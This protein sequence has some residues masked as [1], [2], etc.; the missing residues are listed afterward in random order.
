MADRVLIRL[1]MTHDYDMAVC[2]AFRLAA[3]AGLL[4]RRIGADAL[5][6]LPDR[7]DLPASVS[8][9]VIWKN[10]DIISVTKG[11]D[12]NFIP[13]MKV[14]IGAFRVRFGDDPVDETVPRLPSDRRIVQ[15]DVELGQDFPRE[16]DLNFAALS[17]HWAYHL[18]GPGMRDDL[19]IV[20]A[21]GVVQFDDLGRQVLAGGTPARVLRSALPLPLRAR[22]AQRFA[23]QH[24]DRS[25][26]RVLIPALPAAGLQIR[27]LA[28]T[29]GAT[30][31]QS[32]IYVTLS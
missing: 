10:S 24:D 31:F 21:E 25:G 29:D 27:P 13:V 5:V 17:S 26:P 1:R 18:T 3:P 28:Q 32:D 6:M 16:I 8:L 23:L 2:P 15:L 30:G 9:S 14:P 12:W 11:Y 7:Q 19:R 22:P 4:V 20:D